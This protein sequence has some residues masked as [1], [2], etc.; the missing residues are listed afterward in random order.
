M[1]QTNKKNMF[2]LSTNIS[3]NIKSFAMSANSC[4]DSISHE[5]AICLR[6]VATG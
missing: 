4:E 5:D 1:L 2:K 3:N 6:E